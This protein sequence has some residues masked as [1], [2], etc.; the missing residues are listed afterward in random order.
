MPGISLDHSHH[1]YHRQ[2]KYTRDFNGRCFT[3]Q[4]LFVGKSQT[5]L[6][7]LHCL[8]LRQEAGRQ[9]VLCMCRASSPALYPSIPGETVVLGG[10][11]REHPPP[12][13]VARTEPP[14]RHGMRAHGLLLATAAGLAVTSA[15]STTNGRV[16]EEHNAIVVEGGVIKDLSN[17]SVYAAQCV[18]A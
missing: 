4:R 2:P 6:A 18:I 12:P 15:L 5:D 3:I 1:S 13:P 17:Q 11:C 16:D 9:P 14:R 8:L 10:S 7:H